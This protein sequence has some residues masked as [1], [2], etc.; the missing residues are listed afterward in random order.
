M[1]SFYQIVLILISHNQICYTECQY[2]VKVGFYQKSNY[3]IPKKQTRQ[4]ISQFL[5]VSRYSDT[6]KYT[7]YSDSNQVAQYY[8]EKC[9][10]I[11]SKV[12]RIETDFFKFLQSVTDFSIWIMKELAHYIKLLQ[13][14]K[15]SNCDDWLVESV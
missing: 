2:Y 6:E 7:N 15:A 9:A 13:E 3:T 14:I 1:K 10:K 12:H 5:K 8:E 11:L 4:F